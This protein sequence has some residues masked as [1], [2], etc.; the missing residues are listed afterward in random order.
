[1]YLLAGSLWRSSMHRNKPEPSSKGANHFIRN[2]VHQVERRWL[3][4]ICQ[5][6]QKNV[7]RYLQYNKNF[8]VVARLINACVYVLPG[9]GDLLDDAP[10]TPPSARR[11]R[12]VAG[13]GVAR[14][15][16]LGIQQHLRTPSRKAEFLHRIKQVSQRLSDVLRRLTLHAQPALACMIGN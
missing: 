14:P 10:A 2:M 4:T 12:P 13:W 5:W 9:A 8:A 11:Y 6:F 15:A 3:N 16:L 7:P 1:M